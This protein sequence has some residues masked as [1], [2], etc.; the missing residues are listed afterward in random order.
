MPERSW[1]RAAIAISFLFA[2]AGAAQSAR[3]ALVVNFNLATDQANGSAVPASAATNIMNAVNAAADVF[4]SWSNYTKTVNVYYNSGVATADGNFNGTIRFGMGTQYHNSG[5]AFH[6]LNHVLGAGTYGTWQS[7][8]DLPNQLWTG[9][10]GIAMTHQ[11]FPTNTLKADY[12]IHWVGGGVVQATDTTREGVHIL[13]AIRADMGL[14]NE[15]RYDLPG[16]FNDNGSIGL[17]DYAT[18]VANLHTNVSAL[19]SVQAYIK[20][21]MNL[22]RVV[23]FADFTAFRTAYNAAHGAGALERA[24]GVPEPA[25]MLSLAIGVMAVISRLRKR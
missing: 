14:S 9:A 25:T 11:Y 16:D 22:D 4:N 20:G 8:V 1:N 21:D 10:A 5:V 19:S 17:D 15:N 13:G 24:I 23:N 7:R 18:L 6:E 2:V 3:A 12:H